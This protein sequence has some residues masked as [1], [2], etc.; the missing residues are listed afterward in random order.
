MGQ[1]IE[2]TKPRRCDL[3]LKIHPEQ[4]LLD[5]GWFI[6][7]PDISIGV[8]LIFLGNCNLIEE[9]IGGVNNNQPIPIPDIFH[10][11]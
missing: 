8:I 5:I 1:Q 9:C 11:I 4:G 3:T 2:G 10:N 7:S 6:C